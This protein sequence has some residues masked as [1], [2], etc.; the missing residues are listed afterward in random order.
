MY[1]HFFVV[2]AQRC[3]T[4]YLYRLLDQHPAIQMAR[5]LRPEPK[6]FLDDELFALGVDEYERRHFD[7]GGPPLRG[8]KST[9]YIESERAASR[10][11][12]A[13]PDAAIIALVRDPVE[14]AASNYRLTREH[15]LEMRSIDEALGSA[16][17]ALPSRDGWFEVAG[18]RISTSPFA[19]RARG[20]YTNYLRAYA[21]RFPPDRLT[22]LLFED[23]V[24]TAE[25]IGQVYGRLGVDDG[26]QP[27][28]MDE[29]V[30][31]GP[32]DDG[33]LSEEVAAEL[34]RVFAD[35]NEQL[36]RDFGLDLA[37]WGTAA[38]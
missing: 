6:W 15:G 24:G 1:D 9:T 25:G 26:F 2:G 36:A 20:H 29:V 11:A 7:A 22:V 18:R 32:A 33:P 30:N 31:P 37:P 8:E 5:P 3:G 21:E 16:D 10:I 13:Y 19:Y 27:P 12:H 17:L 14:R 23:L 35:S 4:S 34:R 28:G 38:T